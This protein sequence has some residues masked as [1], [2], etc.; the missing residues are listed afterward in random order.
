V[1]TAF[2]EGDRR[3]LTHRPP[4]Q[5]DLEC[6]RTR[7]QQP[8]PNIEEQFVN[9][10]VK[11]AQEENARLRKEEYD[12]QVQ[13]ETDAAYAKQLHQEELDKSYAMRLLLEEMERM[14]HA[15]P[16]RTSQAELQKRNA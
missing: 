9:A 10:R 4:S 2:F 5:C 16:M 15:R 1:T 12:R 7:A 6:T 3:A 13:N 14:N 8:K 11:N